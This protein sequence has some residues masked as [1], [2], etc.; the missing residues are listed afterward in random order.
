ME[1]LK[2]SAVELN[3]NQRMWRTCR[4]VTEDGGGSGGNGDNTE[5]RVGKERRHFSAGGMQAGELGEIYGRRRRKRL[6]G[7]DRE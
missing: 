3:R 2:N 7:G 4:E 1:S 6:E 5:R